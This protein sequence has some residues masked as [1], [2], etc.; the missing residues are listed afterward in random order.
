VGVTSFFAGLAARA[1]PPVFITAGTGAAAVVA[2]LEASGEIHRVES[3]AAAT[4]LLV[5]GGIPPALESSVAAVHDGMPHPRGTVHLPLGFDQ[6]SLPT[7]PHARVVG[8]AE[9]ARTVIR[10][11]FAELMDGRRSSDPPLLPDTDPNPWRGVGPYG[12]G[13]S[14][15]TGGTPYG[16]PLAEL[17]ADRD[18][19]R[20]DVLPLRIGPLFAHLATG[21]TLEATMAGDVIVEARLADSP[22]A[23]PND[24]GPATIFERALTVQVPIAELEIARARDHLRWVA[25][26]LDVMGL[27]A[28]AMRTLRL[29]A[30]PV[31]DA[32]RVEALGRRLRALRIPALPWAGRGPLAV[33]AVR[34]LA[35]GPV[36]RATGERDDARTE[37]PAY[38]GLGFEP[39]IGTAGDAAER[40]TLRLREAAASLDL[41]Q[42]AGATEAW[43]SGVA[44]SPRG[45]L[46]LTDAPFGRIQALVP[47]LLEGLEWGNAV[48]SLVSLDIDATEVAAVAVS[49]VAA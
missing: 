11:V 41:A 44:E 35:R 16:R 21:V 8:S 39:L 17:G 32:R 18:G 45:R 23:Q 34:D 48:V 40:W 12:Q 49:E 14:G 31:P 10:D 43:G 36:S 15:M 5:V 26:S 30:E 19:L 27:S 24:G 1:T 42:R 4:V 37:E 25:S 38:R 2:Q 20:L 29:A 3:P 7:S 6:E 28:L 22:F 46:T 47:S 9:E 13:G 33:D